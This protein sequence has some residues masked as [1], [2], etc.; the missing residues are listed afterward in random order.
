MKRNIQIFLIVLLLIPLKS[1]PLNWEQLPKAE[2]AEIYAPYLDALEDSLD[3]SPVTARRYL[4]S[5]ETVLETFP[6]SDE[7]RRLLF[8]KGQYFYA[9]GEFQ[10]ALQA[11]LKA[12]RHAEG[13]KHS[14]DYLRAMNNV[15]TVYARMENY[16]ESNQIYRQ[17]IPIADRENAVQRRLIIF[18]NMGNNFLSLGELDSAANYYQRVLPLTHS[19]SFYRAAVEVNLARLKLQQGNYSAA[20][21]L[22]WRSA[23]YA[24][25]V[26]NMELYL[27]SLANIVNSYKE[28]KRFN[29]ALPLAHQ[30]ETL[31]R[32]HRLRL[33]LKDIYINLAEIYQARRQFRLAI[34]YFRRYDALKDSLY[35]ESFTRQLNELRIR[36]E[37]E[38]KERE[39]AYKEKIIRQK[40]KELRLLLFGVIIISILMVWGFWLYRKK[41]Q[42]YQMLV[43][44]SL[45]W[46]QEPYP[47]SRKTSE[48]VVET[49]P[50]DPEK[51]QEVVAQ[52]EK[53]LIGEKWFME[54]DLTIEKLSSRLGIHSRYLSRIIN[55]QYRSNFPNFI[56]SLRIKEAIK[57]FAQEP[58]S[59]YSI[60]GIGET[61]GFKSKSS[62]I[63]A[64]KKNTGVT[65]GYFRKQ[66]KNDRN[67]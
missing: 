60:Q 38:Q 19:G 44:K 56:N 8:L 57:L 46:S 55:E 45:Q 23:A 17:L 54:A 61:V 31:A 36:Y 66:V 30:M 20:R 32:Q 35:N 28:E 58:Y 29:T 2:R 21:S 67:N 24:D 5:L 65:P 7:Y 9:L 64:F 25:S 49:L 53:Y 34:H 52:I 27:E 15:A 63:A 11:Y 42:A 13:A 37:T 41:H 43:Q 6:E 18:L 16:N 50:L 12:A 10:Q 51:I 22:A 3:I 47:E 33:Q 48:T 14:A 62:F 1:R 40:E 4:R 39:L 26:Q 59:N